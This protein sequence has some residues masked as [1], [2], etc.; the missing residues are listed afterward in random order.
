MRAEFTVGKWWRRC[1][2]GLQLVAVAAGLAATVIADS[3]I[4]WAAT[5][6]GLFALLLAYVCQLFADRARALAEQTRRALIV[7]EGLGQ[8]IAPRRETALRLA[9]DR[10]ARRLAERSPELAEPYFATTGKPGPDR[11]RDHLQE[12]VF[13]QAHLSRRTAA[14]ALGAVVALGFVLLG[15][16]L[17]ALNSLD[18]ETTRTIFAKALASFIPFL[19]TTNALRLWWSFQ[20]QATALDGLDRELEATRGPIP[21]SEGEVL[22]LLHEY[23]LLMLQAPEVPDAVYDRHRDELN[24]AWTESR[25]REVVGESARRGDAG[26]A[27]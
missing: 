26:V 27:R 10:W 9:F 7:A 14:Y 2:L 22:R 15:G 11:L 13:W 23:N 17:L 3:G 25:S 19:V 5:L 8:P 24:R 12:S 20:A 16:V 6:I 1:S 4:V 21:P 18:G